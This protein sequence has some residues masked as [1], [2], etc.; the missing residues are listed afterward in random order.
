MLAV[1]AWAELGVVPAEE[2][3][4]AGQRAP[5][6][7]AAF[8]QACRARAG[9]RPRRGRLRRR[10]PGAIGAPAG[11]WVHYG[12]TSRDVVDTAAAGR[13]PTPPTS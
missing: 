13:S 2:P 1:E 10:G 3:P 9:H 12:L 6:V 7:D 8:V 5:V 4:P 11:K